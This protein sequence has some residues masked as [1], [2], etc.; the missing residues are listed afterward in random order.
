MPY[1]S[2][3]FPRRPRDS[4]RVHV[5]THSL[6]VSP[7]LARTLNVHRRAWVFIRSRAR[8]ALPGT[9]DAV[10]HVILELETDV[11]L[12]SWRKSHRLPWGLSGKSAVR[13]CVILITRST[14]LL[15]VKWMKCFYQKTKGPWSCFY[16]Q[17]SHQKKKLWFCPLSC[18]LSWL[19]LD[20]LYVCYS[21]AKTTWCFAG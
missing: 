10:S 1:C 20:L 15:R 7:P 14:S 12:C 2:S 18:C 5:D 13:V 3:L 19:T 4:C 21:S 6:T 16:T 9:V 8:L 17:C 11:E